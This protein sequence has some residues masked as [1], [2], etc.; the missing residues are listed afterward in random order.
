[1]KPLP[2][3]LHSASQCIH[4]EKQEALSNDILQPM[5]RAEKSL[6]QLLYGILDFS[7]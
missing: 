7:T 2:I 6:W 1:M 3:E 4:N 5:V